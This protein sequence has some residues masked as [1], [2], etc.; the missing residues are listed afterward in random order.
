MDENSNVTKAQIE[1]L[2]SDPA[3]Y[4]RFIKVF[5]EVINGNFSLTLKDTELAASLQ[6]QTTGWMTQALGGDA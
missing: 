2:K 4:R 1:R 3:L 6:K 5:E